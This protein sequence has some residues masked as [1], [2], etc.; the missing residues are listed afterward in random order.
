MR[1]DAISIGYDPPKNV[2]VIIEV[3]ISA[4]PI[5]YKMDEAAETL[6][7]DRFLHKSLRDSCSF[8]RTPTGRTLIAA[9]EMIGWVLEIGSATTLME[10]P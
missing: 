9:A 10:S 8:L 1:I 4:E 3:P 6:V 7:A 5:K 2:N